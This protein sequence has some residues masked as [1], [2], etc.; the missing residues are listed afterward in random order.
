MVSSN[1]SIPT[2]PLPYTDS[3]GQAAILFSLTSSQQQA[4]LVFDPVSG[5][6]ETIATP[7]TIMTTLS[8]TV[9]NGVVYG[10]GGGEQRSSWRSRSR[11]CSLSGSTRRSRACASSSSTRS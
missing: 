9:S 6:Q 8:M 4:L 2:T 5:S 1:S 7:G 11:R 3:T 10:G